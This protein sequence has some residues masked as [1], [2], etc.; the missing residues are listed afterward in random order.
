MILLLVWLARQ[1]APFSPWAH[2][3]ILTVKDIEINDLRNRY[4]LTKGATQ[5]DVHSSPFGPVHTLSEHLHALIPCRF[6]K[7]PRLQ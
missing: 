4:M 7:R 3:T 1:L 5:T 2:W 6:T